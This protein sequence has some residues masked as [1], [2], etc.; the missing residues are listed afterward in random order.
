MGIRVLL[1]DDHAVVRQGVSLLLSLHD[2][3][4]VI[5]EAANGA[6]ALSLAAELLPDVVVMDLLMPV[7]D[8][9]Q[10]TA[11][12]RAELPSVAVL[13]LTSALDE[14]L[15]SAAVR[16]GAI[17]YLL[18]TADGDEVATAIRAAAA[19]LAQLAPEAAASLMRQVAGGGRPEPV[20]LTERESGVLRLL[21]AGLSNKEIAR[22]LAIGEPTVKTHVGNL[23]TKLGVQ[24]RTQAALAAAKRGLG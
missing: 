1:V 15:V 22:E 9:V 13:A 7:L 4:E 5:G 21:A 23:F 6:D 2:D 11:R 24:S 18:K 12:I 3:I 10:A 17:G 19:G 14:T 8:G 20:A 16:A